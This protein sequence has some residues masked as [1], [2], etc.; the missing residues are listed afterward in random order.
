MS[1]YSK[2]LEELTKSYLSIVNN[3]KNQQT[4][5]DLDAKLFVLTEELGSL[6]ERFH[7][8]PE[9]GLITDMVELYITKISPLVARRRELQYAETDIVRSFDDTLHLVEEPYTL[10]S[11]LINLDGV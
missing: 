3:V 11:L 9:P 8:T 1:Q 10:E 2:P 5:Q 6:V 4:I 7:G